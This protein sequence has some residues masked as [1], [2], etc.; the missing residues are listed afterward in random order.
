[1]KIIEDQA[2]QA[3]AK[4]IYDL[5]DRSGLSNEWEAIDEDVQQEIID[6]WRAIVAEAMEIVRVNIV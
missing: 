6:K 5:T 2:K 4:I 3:V 1:M